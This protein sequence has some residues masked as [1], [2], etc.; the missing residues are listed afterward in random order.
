MGDGLPESCEQVVIAKSLLA[1]M[2]EEPAHKAGISYFTAPPLT[3]CLHLKMAPGLALWVG[4][5]FHIL[6]KGKVHQISTFLQTKC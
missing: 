5:C 1:E 2:E 3:P 6:P 4:V